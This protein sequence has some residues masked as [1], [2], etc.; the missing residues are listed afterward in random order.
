MSN[1]QLLKRTIQEEEEGEKK[2]QKKKNRDLSGHTGRKRI[3]YCK[4][5]SV[6]KTKPRRRFFCLDAA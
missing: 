1:V 4:G 5:L 2:K 6:T 3:S